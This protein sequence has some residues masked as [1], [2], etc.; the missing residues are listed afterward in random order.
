VLGVASPGYAQGENQALRE[1]FLRESPE[2]WRQYLAAAA[3]LQGTDEFITHETEKGK[4]TRVSRQGV[5]EVKQCGDW[6]YLKWVELAPVPKGIPVATGQLVNSKYTAVVRQKVKDGGWLLEDLNLVSRNDG[7]RPAKAD[8]LGRMALNS[9]ASLLWVERQMLPDVVRNPTFSLKGVAPA[10]K[11]PKLV[12]IAFSVNRPP[13]DWKDAPREAPRMQGWLIL[14]PNHHWIITEGQLNL[15]Y[16]GEIPGDLKFRSE[17]R[18][19]RDGAA[20]P[21]RMIKHLFLPEVERKEEEEH[22]FSLVAQDAVPE[23]EFSLS[24]FGLPEPV[25]VTFPRPTPWYLWF[26]GGGIGSLIAGL[27]LYTLAQRRRLSKAAS[28][29]AGP[30]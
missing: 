27:G 26:A 1:R 20:I 10:D 12:R 18:E 22:R 2:K 16:L 23:F 4:D 19:G 11:D 7:G 3:R 29:N 8:Q 9:L 21:T 25:G 6:S 15:V 5:D 14:D 13:V 17:F 28:E 30:K 24:T